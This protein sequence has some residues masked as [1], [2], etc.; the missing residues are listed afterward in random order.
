MGFFR[1]RAPSGAKPPRVCAGRPPAPAKKRRL[2]ETGARGRT[3]A[4]A[5]GIF[6]YSV[7][8]GILIVEKSLCASPRP[9]LP[10]EASPH[11][12]SPLHLRASFRRETTIF[13]FNPRVCAKQASVWVL[14]SGEQTRLFG[15]AFSLSPPARPLHSLESVAPEPPIRRPLCPWP[16]RTRFF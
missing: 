15:L 6:S 11:P 10:R 9:C 2:P 4:R 13:A 5:A 12:R 16:Q 1:I 3:C 14:P 7:R 8:G